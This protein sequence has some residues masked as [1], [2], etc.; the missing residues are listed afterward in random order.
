MGACHDMA[1]GDGI[2]ENLDELGDL[3]ALS[4]VVARLSATLGRDDVEVGEVE[5]IIR[6]DPVVA[7]KVISAANAAAY[8]SHLPTTTIRAALLRLGLMRVRRLA[9]LVSLYSAVPLRPAMQETF[10][11]HSLVTAYTAEAI[12]RR[13]AAEAVEPDTAFLAGLL[14]DI[15]LLVLASHYPREL[16]AVR[17]FAERR[18]TR[19]WEAERALLGIEH[20]EIGGRLAEHWSFP[21]EIT[22]VIHYHHRVDMAP[23]QHQLVAAIV[24]LAEAGCT[25]EEGIDLGEGG[26]VEPGDPAL[27]PLGLD[28]A[29]LRGVIDEARV[30]ARTAGGVLEATR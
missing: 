11:A 22:G 7:A 18:D 13:A 16:N 24:R 29:A 4:P 30:E 21:K 17:S 27:V 14:H 9:L 2:R 20:G 3:P 8:A 15:G 1:L 28:E 6:Q 10:W 12:A 5:A 25:G 26:Q 23:R 19:L